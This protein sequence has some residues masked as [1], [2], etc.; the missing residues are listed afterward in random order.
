MTLSSFQVKAKQSDARRRLPRCDEVLLIN[1]TEPSS[2]AQVISE[3]AELM[4]NRM[5][6]GLIGHRPPTPN[7]VGGAS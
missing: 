4:N 6:V 1:A 2:A 7:Q 3:N 5:P